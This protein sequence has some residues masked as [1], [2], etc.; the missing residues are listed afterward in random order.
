M[1]KSLFRALGRVLGRQTAKVLAPVAGKAPRPEPGQVV[2]RPG[3]TPTKLINFGLDFGTSSTKV[4]VRDVNADAT[5][6]YAFRDTVEEYG[7]FCWPTAIRV[8][9]G[10]MSFG[11]PA[12]KGTGGRC[13]RSFKICMGCERQV[14]KDRPCQTA[15]CTAAG[16]PGTFALDQGNADHIP[17][18]ASGLASLYLANLMTESMEC[19]Q[20][21]RLFQG[22]ARLSY[23]VAAPLDMTQRPAMQDSFERTLYRAWCM[24]GRVPQGISVAHAGELLASAEKR[25][26][27]SEEE[28]FTFVRPETHAA[29]LGYALSGRALPGLYMSADVGAGT[30]DIAAFRYFGEGDAPRD[31]AYYSAKTD[32]VGCDDIDRATLGLVRRTAGTLDVADLELLAEIRTAKH[33]VGG[34]SLRIAG[35]ELNLRDIE[36]GS[37]DVLDRIA[38]HYR[39]T[40]GRAFV[41]RKENAQA[42]RVLHVLLIGGGNKLPFI[43]RLFEARNPSEQCGH[44]IKRI[45]TIPVKLPMG[46]ISVIGA[47]GATK[48]QLA[49]S[50]HLLT[51]AYGL[52]Y[53]CGET[54]GYWLPHE[55]GEVRRRPERP[56]PPEHWHTTGLDPR[57][58]P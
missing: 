22:K 11:S 36:G 48:E 44:V 31:V 20:G 15:F 24:G 30:T 13:I 26:L 45:E 54:S 50:E 18:G 16:Q 52:A 34:G 29:M 58:Q 6:A 1:L 43:A 8:H 33:D 57:W 46:N 47:T 7:P 25:P 53:H 2:A 17:F 49:E 3:Q 23:N 28:R 38:N 35:T 12:E 9:R 41:S 27:P 42:W 5:Y 10:M 14:F 4:F 39:K 19:L 51:V 37:A 55:V 56:S 32:L 21:T 40:W